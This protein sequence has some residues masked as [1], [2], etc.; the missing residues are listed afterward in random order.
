MLVLGICFSAV[1][2]LLFY[3]VYGP[4]P[5]RTAFVFFA[6]IFLFFLFGL[7]VP[8]IVRKQ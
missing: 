4:N 3:F 8:C 1:A 7:F 5:A 2:N 6:V